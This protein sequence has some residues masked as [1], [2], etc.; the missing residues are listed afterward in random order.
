M[1]PTV[2]QVLNLALNLLSQRMFTFMA[3][4][5]TAGAFAWT[6]A[7]PDTLRIVS[8]SIFG[9]LCLLYQRKDAEKE[10]PSED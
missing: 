6:L 1:N 8:A 5:L 10:K 3:L 2:A 4:L 7:L 9:V